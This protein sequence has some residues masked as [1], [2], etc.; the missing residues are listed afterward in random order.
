MSP[1]IPSPP[2]A[3]DTSTPPSGLTLFLP[4]RPR[5]HQCHVTVN[6]KSRS[7]HNI[8][9]NAFP[10]FFVLPTFT[11]LGSKIPFQKKSSSAQWMSHVP[12]IP[13]PPHVIDTFTPPSGLKL[14]LP[15]QG[16]I[17]G[18]SR[19]PHDIFQNAFPTFLHFQH[20]PN[21]DPKY[22]FKKKVPRPNMFRI[23]LPFFHTC[24]KP[25][26]QWRDPEHHVWPFIPLSSSWPFYDPMYFDRAAQGFPIPQSF[27]RSSAIFSTGLGSDL[28]LAPQNTMKAK[29]STRIPDSPEF[30]FSRP[31]GSNVLSS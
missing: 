19:S 12:S 20:S 29:P 17:N 10:T 30:Q 26:P 22:L 21:L 27:R 6:G 24:H 18:K 7:P 1:S 8:F 23:R 25:K 2:H 15:C 16:S 13:S 14:F 31:F 4:W 9:Q 5:V 3:I 28:P 11:K